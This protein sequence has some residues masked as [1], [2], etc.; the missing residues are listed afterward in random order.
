MRLLRHQRRL[1][2]A[3][4]DELELAGIGVDV[5]DG[6]NAGHAGL[7]FLR[8]DRDQVL[9]ELQSPIGDRPELHGEPEERQHASV[10]CS[11][12]RRRRP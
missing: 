11:K 4:E 1:V 9:V 12:W 5:A 2:E 6:E 3:R 8:I 10:G 7:E